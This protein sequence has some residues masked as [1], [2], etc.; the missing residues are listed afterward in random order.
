MYNTYESLRTDCGSHFKQGVPPE[1]LCANLKCASL[2]FPT[3][4]NTWSFILCFKL[5]LEFKFDIQVGSK[6]GKL[7]LKWTQSSDV[8]ESERRLSGSASFLR[9]RLC[10]FVVC[11]LRPSRFIPFLRKGTQISEIY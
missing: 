2:R 11:D 10:V 5:N 1:S 7:E 4:K 3:E 8:R 6:L 9:G